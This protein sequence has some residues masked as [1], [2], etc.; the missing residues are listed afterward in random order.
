MGRS[1]LVDV[2]RQVE[3]VS[4]PFRGLGG[5]HAHIRPA[6]RLMSSDEGVHVSTKAAIW[7]HSLLRG[8]ED[9][10]G[11]RARQVRVETN[12]S[13]VVRELRKRLG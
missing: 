2:L 4:T 7:G 11:Y 1:A 8:V 3:T 13:L 5:P 10:S 9:W 12:W 6:V